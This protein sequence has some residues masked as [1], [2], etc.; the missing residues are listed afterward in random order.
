M[1][2]SLLEN[3]GFTKVVGFSHMARQQDKIAHSDDVKR[4]ANKQ[5]SSAA[6]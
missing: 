6:A 3:K 1:T 5:V 4:A 2:R